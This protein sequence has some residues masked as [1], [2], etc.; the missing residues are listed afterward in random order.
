MNL[1]KKSILFLSLFALFWS[2]DD[3][4]S[5]QGTTHCRAVCAWAV[6]CKEGTWDFNRD[7]LYGRCVDALNMADPDCEDDPF[8]AEL[9]AECGEAINSLA[10]SGECSPF[11][12][13]E[14]EQ[15]AGEG[16]TPEVCEPFGSVG[17]DEANRLTSP[18]D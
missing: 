4:E 11:T 7:A 14:E 2:C 12:G 18:S 15:A 9:A 13:T 3:S 6:D 1:G 16:L 5:E 10:A 8:A 17:I